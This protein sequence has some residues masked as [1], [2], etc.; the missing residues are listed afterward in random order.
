MEGAMHNPNWNSL[1]Q[2]AV[3]QKV[4]KG[5][6]SASA[7]CLCLCMGETHLVRLTD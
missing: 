3:S 5:V 7:N 1:V 4:Q 2:L 6:H